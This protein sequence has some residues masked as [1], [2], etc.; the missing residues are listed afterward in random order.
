TQGSFSFQ[1]VA[2]QYPGSDHPVI[3]GLSFN[4][5]PG[6]K[7]G[8]IGRIGSGKT[9]LARVEA[10]LVDRAR[11]EVRFDGKPLPAQLSQR[12][13]EQYRQIQI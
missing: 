10:G 8:I 4:V 1:N 3:N 2:F 13:P 5:R 11:G 7:I 12:T 9:T 6:E